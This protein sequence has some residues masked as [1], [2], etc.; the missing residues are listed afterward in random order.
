[1]PGSSSHLAAQDRDRNLTRELDEFVNYDA[2]G[3]ADLIKKKEVT[4]SE[5]VEVFIRRIETINPI[6]NCIATPTF[7]RARA[8][9]KTIP[10]DTV[11]AGVPSLIKDMI[12]IGGVRR[13]D[14]SRLLATN[15]PQKSVAWIEAFE[16]AGST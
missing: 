11:F 2:T 3:L 8:K 12:D 4:P 5:L 6:I 1:M 10:S 7:E 9:A 13:T 14:G 16:R 15:I